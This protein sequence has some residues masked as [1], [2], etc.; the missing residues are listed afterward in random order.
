MISVI[1]VNFNGRH[2]LDECLSALS[3]QSF[4]EFETILVDNASTDDSIELVRE[5][6]G[7]VR[8]I[9]NLQNVG[10]AAGVNEGIRASEGE[11]VLTLNNDTIADRHFIGELKRAMD[12]DSTL[13]MCAS[14]MLFA[15]G[16]INSTGI[17]ISR[18]GAAWDRGMFEPD[19]GQFE[20]K[21]EVFGACAGGAIYRKKMLDRI[22]LFDEDFF[23]FME[24]VDLAF[25]ARLAGWKCVYIPS[26]RVV[27]LHGGTTGFRSNLSIYYGNRNLIWYV[28]KNYPVK[29]LLVYSPWI[30]GRNCA[31]I[32]YYIYKGNG[33]AIIEAKIDAVLGIGKMVKK[34]KSIRIIISDSE[35]NRWI[36][37]F[38][39]FKPSQIYSLKSGNAQDR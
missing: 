17:C 35:M 30:I 9:E 11:Y 39:S 22:G 15:D 12:E 2:F 23:L 38:A 1:I 27:H 10:F 21:E 36:K 25:R 5:K 8:V 14:K 34:R 18:S 29:T 7:W 19:C 26:A 33:R 28:V 20:R 13:G 31:V 6:Y 37:R 16:R 3:T 24:D 32:P 4:Q